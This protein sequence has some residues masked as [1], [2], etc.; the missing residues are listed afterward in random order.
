MV[1][2]DRHVAQVDELSDG[3]VLDLTGVLK[4]MLKVTRA[5]LNPGGFNIGINMGEIAG[6]GIA[7]HIHIHLVPR[8]A[9]DTNFMPVTAGTKVISQS[10]TDLYRRF[11]R[12]LAKN[13][14]R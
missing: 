7:G 9:A 3:E 14:Q 11:V 1:V 8:W 12:E 5:V 13:K 2:P 6:A 4:A 10:L